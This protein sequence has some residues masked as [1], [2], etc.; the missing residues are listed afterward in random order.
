MVRYNSER[1]CGP[2]HSTK[3]F[4]HFPFQVTQTIPDI[5]IADLT[6]DSRQVRPESLFVAVRGDTN[7]GHRFIQ[8][9]IDRGAVAVV[10]S[11]PDLELKVPYILVADSRQAFPYLAAAF[12]DFP[13]RKLTVIGVTG[14]DGKTTT[15]NLIY[16]NLLAA[17]KRRNHFYS[18]ADC[19]QVF[20]V[21]CD[22]PFP[23]VQRTRQMVHGLSHVV[24]A[25]SRISPVCVDA[26]EFDL[27]IVTNITHEHLDYAVRIKLSSCKSRLFTMLSQT[28]VKGGNPV[29]LS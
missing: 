2:T 13:A 28:L 22:A 21:P 27:A 11:E 29:L 3:L 26:C 25:A 17:G 1:G 20:A 9:A 8:D 23:D 19:D 6:A 16:Q 10:G 15:S 5:S 4:A 7:D 14:T 18:T 12:Y 24:E